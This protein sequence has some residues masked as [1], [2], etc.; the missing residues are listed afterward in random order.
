MTVSQLNQPVKQEPKPV[1]KNARR[2][3][4]EHEQPQ[5]KRARMQ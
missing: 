4:T 5:A 3:K 1:E 2:I